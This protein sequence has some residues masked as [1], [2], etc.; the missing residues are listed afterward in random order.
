M[1]TVFLNGRFLSRDEAR[2]SAFDA[3]YQHG[4]GL[5]ETMLG[6]C[7]G[8][9]PRRPW[10]VRLE[11]HLER[12]IESAGTL[13]LSDSL[14]APAL[15]EAVLGTLER[16]T[17]PT[18]RVR[19][20]ITGGDLNL[21]DRRPRGNTAPLDPTILIIAQPAT[22]YP[23]EMFEAGV[24]VVVADYKANPLDPLA[25]HKT[26]HY[27]ARLR[28]LQQAAA[29]RAGE[30]LVLQVTNYLAGGCVSNAILVK[31][32][33]LI[34]P[35]ARGEEASVASGSASKPG[36]RPGAPTPSPVLPGVTRAWALEWAASERVRIER[37][38]VSIGD[39]LGADELM[40]TNS[41]WG[42]LPCVRVEHKT[43]GA[44]QPGPMAQRLM[45]AWHATIGAS[46]DAR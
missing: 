45:D 19:L 14:R 21:M 5:F 37:R 29:A 41:S 27:W 25:G 26:I 11:E 32:G 44:G 30:A 15:A 16:S 6:G 22:E 39:V 34:T 4:V 46:A 9:P 17:L 23:D 10:V 8:E 42:V 2:V 7:S 40:L 28:E 24:G 38:M 33:V 1:T 18:A 36:E 20:T 12:L 31:D 3:A 13:G 43:I 35:I